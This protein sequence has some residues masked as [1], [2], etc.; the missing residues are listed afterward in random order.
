[1]LNTNKSF[2]CI[3]EWL[4][5]NTNLPFVFENYA[6]QHSQHEQ[7]NKVRQHKRGSTQIR[8]K[9]RHNCTR[10]NVDSTRSRLLV[11][12]C[13]VQVYVFLSEWIKWGL[14]VFYRDELDVDECCNTIKDGM[15]H[16]QLVLK[17]VSLLISM[18][19]IV[20]Q[21]SKQGDLFPK[22][23]SLCPA[24]NQGTIA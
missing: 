4:I 14:A 11:Q 19:F 21:I 7:C 24:A 22:W 1:M 5:S 20:H 3:D 6:A 12:H 18:R 23:S 8:Q 15:H 17:R 2:N 10:W 9:G 16:I 13:G